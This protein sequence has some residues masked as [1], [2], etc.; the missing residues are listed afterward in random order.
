[1]ELF[2]NHSN[3]KDK[4]NHIDEN[5]F[6]TIKI[7]IDEINFGLENVSIVLKVLK[8]HCSDTEKNK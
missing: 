4:V 2:K 8:E 7:L 6:T 1:M 3:W 5:I